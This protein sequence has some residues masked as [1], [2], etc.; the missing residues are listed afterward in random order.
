MKKI[1]ILKWNYLFYA[2]IIVL[3]LIMPYIISL[4]NSS[5]TS[6]EMQNI[7]KL[8]SLKVYN[9]DLPEV[10][11]PNELVG[12][13]EKINWQNYDYSSLKNNENGIIWLKIKIPKRKFKN[14][15]LYISRIDQNYELYH[16]GE[17][18]YRFG[19]VSKNPKFNGSPHHYIPIPEYLEGQTV[20][21]RVASAFSSIGLYANAMYG[22]EKSF[23][24]INMP[25]YF[26]TIGAAFIFIGFGI[27]A[28]IFYRIYKTDVYYLYFTFLSTTIAVFLFF[29]NRVPYEFTDNYVACYYWHC[30]SLYSFTYVL[31]LYLNAV[32]GGVY[33]RILKI[34]TN[35]YLVF[36]AISIIGSIAGFYSIDRTLRV[37][38]YIIIIMII[39][40]SWAILRQCFKGTKNQRIVGSAILIMGFLSLVE[41]FTDMYSVHIFYESLSLGFIYIIVSIFT[42]M[43]KEMIEIRCNLEKHV[44]KLQ[45]KMDEVD[46]AKERIAFSE[47]RH[48][49]LINALE[50]VVFT[51]D[52][53]CII[54]SSNEKFSSISKKL[55]DEGEINLID[56][57]YFQDTEPDISREMVRQ[58]INEFI[59]GENST[60]IRL[61]FE[62][63]LTGEPL[64]SSLSLSK[65]PGKEKSQTGFI[66]GKI[67]FNTQDRLVKYFNHESGSYEIGNYILLCDEITHR[68]TRNLVRYM[69][70]ADLNLLR[71]A[72]REVIMNAIEH[73]NLNITFDEK[74]DY[75]FEDR[76]SELLFKRNNHPEYKSR[77][78][79]I[80][81]DI[82]SERAV[83][84][85]KD[86]GD[87]F[88][89]EK[90]L[91]TDPYDLN[92]ERMTHGRGL[93]MVKNIFD[94]I[95]YVEP[96]NEVHL[97]KYYN[98]NTKKSVTV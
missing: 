45:E 31:A 65:I 96:G 76:Y 6:N 55:P 91:N 8:D 82:T 33:Q 43:T 83:Y 38:N 37:Y 68:I 19:E 94:E 21:M 1:A 60:E 27:F 84:I 32:F 53:N 47:Q 88:N 40:F 72:L 49:I 70:D 77:T 97:I 75:L 18:F 3:A 10:S 48:K 61:N 50:D 41:V 52:E 17:V 23:I 20:Y 93:I 44:C 92:M 64:D 36:V 54:K 42:V 15:V 39:F 98:G 4:L 11:N 16:N 86:A 87:G 80:N 69:N 14:P 25:L 85:V 2:G 71:I 9:D 89:F 79:V 13:L 81:Y 73:G 26:Q 67:S 95:E 5:I 59:A 90:M 22:S 35:I 62:S 63:T 24:I 29:R 30:I 58:K 66:I 7:V 28:F 78:V 34:L 74:T 56:L 51:M 57:V 12:I 46:A